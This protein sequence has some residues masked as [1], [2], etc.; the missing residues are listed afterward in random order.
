MDERKRRDEAGRAPPKPSRVPS[1]QTVISDG[2]LGAANLERGPERENPEGSAL[3]PIP[4]E[5]R[6]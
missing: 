5:E 3:R 1:E 6:K 4:P 2:Q